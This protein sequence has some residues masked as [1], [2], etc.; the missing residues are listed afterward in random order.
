M[1]PMRKQPSSV[2][3]GLSPTFHPLEPPHGAVANASPAGESQGALP[4]V[5]STLGNYKLLF[6]LGQGTTSV[7]F[8]GRHRKLQ[9]PVAVKVLHRDAIQD[10]PRLLSL[11]VSEA[12]LLARINH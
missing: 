5:G 10:S 2:H 3:A 7:V 4:R 11:L 9:I 8:E 6:R 12:V 1:S